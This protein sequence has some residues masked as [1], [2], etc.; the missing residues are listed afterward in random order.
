M[1]DTYRAR[2]AIRD[3]GMALGVPFVEIDL[4]AKSLPHV[5]ARN[6]SR[7]LE[8]LPELR[9]LNLKNPLLAMMISLAQ[10]LDG[11][12]RHLA[13]HPCAIVLSDGAFLDRALEW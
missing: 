4:I 9:T 13:M 10:R 8:T 3:T 6:I 1:I 11:L 2:H 7:A 5:R 12:P